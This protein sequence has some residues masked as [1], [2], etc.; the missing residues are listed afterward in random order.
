MSKEDLNATVTFYP[1]ENEVQESEYIVEEITPIST[2]ERLL[3]YNDQLKISLQNG[4]NFTELLDTLIN[5]KNSSEL[6]DATMKLIDYQLDSS[7]LVYPQQYSRADYYLIFINRILEIHQAESV[8]LQSNEHEFE[9]HHEYPGIDSLGYFVFKVLENNENGAYY[10]E[11]NTGLELFYLD[12]KQRVLR[13]NSRALTELLI[14]K[15]Q[16]EITYE[17]LTQFTDY[18]LAIG[19]I[20]KAEYSFDVDFN[21]LDTSNTAYYAISDP[22]MPQQALDRLFILASETG[23]ML[24]SGAQNEAILELGQNVKMTIFQH[25]GF[26]E[27]ARWVIA[28]TDPDNAVS[29]FDV[30]GR[31]AFLSDWYLDNLNSLEIKSDPLYF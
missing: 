12:F 2:T 24:L 25:S 19:D 20:L 28:I 1:K 6:L 8:V 14:V 31:Y 10:V 16:D 27:E 7:Y 13:F 22:D 29:F 5:T 17:V 30:L 18:L 3:D 23:H 26:G 15:Y 21:I 11:K 4:I 9:L